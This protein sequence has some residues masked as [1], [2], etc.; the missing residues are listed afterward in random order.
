V[1]HIPEG[2]HSVTP[3]LTVR[4]ASA[5]ME[6]YT[7][8]FNAVECFRM[9]EA[10]SGKIM[11]AELRIGNCTLMISD[12]YPDWGAVAPQIAKGGVFMIYV[13]DADAAFA[14]AIAAGATVI[15]PPADQFWG[16]RCGRVADPFGYRWTLAQ[17]VK[18]V[19]TE[20]I[21]RLS[22]SWEG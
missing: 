15:M 7:K 6:F 2:Y 21:I 18:D 11:H 3:S 5:A 14:Q 19:S 10:K 20:E 4:D 16:D 13:P 9:P 22:A 12:E 17:K 1:N 8:A